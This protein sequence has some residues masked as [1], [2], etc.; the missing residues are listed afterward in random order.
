MSVNMTKIKC[1]QTRASKPFGTGE[2]FQEPDSALVAYLRQ[3]ERIPLLSAEQ[4]RALAQKIQDAR[5]RMETTLLRSPV[6]LEW[7]KRTAGQIRDG[8]LLSTE[9]L[10]RCHPSPTKPEKEDLFLRERF[11]SFALVSPDPSPGSSNPGMGHDDP[12]V[13]Q[14]EKNAGVSPGQIGTSGA[15]HDVCIK[16]HILMDLYRTLRKRIDLT[17][18]DGGVCR[19][20]FLREGMEKILSDVNR[21]QQRMKQARDDLVRANL[22]LVITVAKKYI[23]RG[24]SLPDLI[25]EGNIGLMKAADKFDYQKGY[26]FS[27]HAHWWIMQRINRAIADQGRIIR[28][29][30]RII[31]E[32]TKIGKM[33]SGL[34]SQLGRQPNASEMAEAADISV[35]E[36]DKL[37]H[38]FRVEPISLDDWTKDHGHTFEESVA[39]N[40]TASPF[41]VTARAEVAGRVREVLA[42]LTPRENEIIRMRFGI[43][44]DKEYT[45]DEVGKRLGLSHERIR[46]IQNRSLQKLKRSERKQR[47]MTLCE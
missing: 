1:R 28:I 44:E 11:L 9:V 26:R 47:L 29:P 46:Q 23:N 45:L 14:R 25:Q 2:L 6:G 40:H 7:I 16:R 8:R 4:E 35:N 20:A 38:V 19:D 33:L 18:R 32:S 5:R 42:S 30:S 15:C 34:M 27:T 36:I 37:F 43:G 3:T 12:V 39:D 22:R 41:E 21:F 24:L 31:E 10:E 13:S 17:K